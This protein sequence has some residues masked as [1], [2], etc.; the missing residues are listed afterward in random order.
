MNSDL[1]PPKKSATEL[2]LYLWKII[3]L[4]EISI[5]DLIYSISFDLFLF[6]PNKAKKFVDKAISSKL[7][8]KKGNMLTLSNRLKKTLLDWQEIRKKEIQARINKL[9][10]QYKMIEKIS[11]NKSNGFSSLD[12]GTINRAVGVP[13]DAFTYN[14]MDLNK[15]IIKGKVS[16]SKD[17]PYVFEINKENKEIIHNCHDFET[18][19]SPNKKFCKHL[20]KLFLLLKEKNESQL[21]AL[22]EDI[23]GN[24]N[25]WQF[26]C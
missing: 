25:D 7:L 13:E 1:E 11:E 5:N 9:E 12:K 6:S 24:I 23:S 22:L 20:T 8:T 16:G 18:R 15:G 10:N 3:D 4:P 19:R 17:T 14:E 21:C 26:Q 2:L